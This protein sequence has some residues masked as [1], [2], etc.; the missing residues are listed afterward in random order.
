MHTDEVDTDATL[1]RRLLAAQFPRWAELPVERVESF[2]TDFAI[3]RLG[4]ELAE[5]GVDDATWERGRGQAISVGLIQL[6]YY[7]TTNP[8]LAAIGRNMVEE[9]LAE[10]GF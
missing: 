4:D 8:T 10:R 5:L 3:Y 7:E 2:G 1:V 9:A 6:P